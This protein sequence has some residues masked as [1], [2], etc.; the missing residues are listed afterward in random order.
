[1]AAFFA[2]LIAVRCRVGPRGD[3]LHA[4]TE[5]EHVLAAAIPGHHQRDSRADENDDENP[6][7]PRCV[8]DAGTPPKCEQQHHQRGEHGPF[9]VQRNGLAGR[10][11]HVQI[12]HACQTR[13]QCEQGG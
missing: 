12:E 3:S 13:G 10:R 9:H 1:M 6:R 7:G 2:N 4:H 8:G 5:F 11:A